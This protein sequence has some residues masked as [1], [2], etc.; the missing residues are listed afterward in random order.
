MAKAWHTMLYTTV[1]RTSVAVRSFFALAVLLAGC[2][3][4]AVNPETLTATPV[5]GMPQIPP[6]RQ[7]RITLPPG[8]FNTLDFMALHGCALQITL[9]KYQSALGQ[10]ASDSQRLLLDLEYLNLAPDCIARK[11]S[12]HNIVLAEQL[13]Q[14]KKFK[15]QQLS[16]RIFNATFA[17]TEFQ[18][19]WNRRYKCCDNAGQSQRTLSA[20]AAL[21]GSVQRWL[22]GDYQVSNIEFEIQLSEVAKGSATYMRSEI[23]RATVTTLE[24]QLRPILPLEYQRWCQLRNTVFDHEPSTR[25]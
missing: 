14:E 15:L 7:L 18:Q 10:F 12:E 5:A 6:T 24:T 1:P 22:L 8:T 9:G 13:L 3:G 2:D 25:F 16:S 20:F 17:N 23:L 19:F 11:Q 21:N 4:G